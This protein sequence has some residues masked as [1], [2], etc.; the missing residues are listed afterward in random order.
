LL[1]FV[2]WHH[3]PVIAKSL[4]RAKFNI[5]FPVSYVPF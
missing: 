5:R 1:M 2:G 4:P 3:V